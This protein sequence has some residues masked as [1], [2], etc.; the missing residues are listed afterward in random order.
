M[1]TSALSRLVALCVVAY[2]GESLPFNAD[3]LL[4]LVWI[5]SWGGAAAW[6]ETYVAVG[7]SLIYIY[8]FFFFP[9]P[10][11]FLVVFRAVIDCYEERLVVWTAHGS[12]A[13]FVLGSHI[14]AL[15]LILFIYFLRLQ[16][17]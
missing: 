1:Y 14:F 8:L 2:A 15:F 17:P 11:S 5:W 10:V 6:L 13:E 3:R 16:A 4:R 12:V 9:S 7:A